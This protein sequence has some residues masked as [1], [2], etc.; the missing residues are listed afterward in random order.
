VEYKLIIG[1]G[2]LAKPGAKIAY[3]LDNLSAAS[4][5]TKSLGDLASKLAASK[6]MM[7]GP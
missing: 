3:S 2:D 7:G 1:E 6:G 5:K 4:G